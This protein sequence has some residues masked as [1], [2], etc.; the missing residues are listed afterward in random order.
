MLQPIPEGV[1]D[2]VFSS[3]KPAHPQRELDYTFANDPGL[4]G[5][6]SVASDPAFA[7]DPEIAGGKILSITDRKLEG[8][9]AAASEFAESEASDTADGWTARKASTPSP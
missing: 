6:S 1:I 4:T 7:N 3:A 5:N 2:P 9:E 8:A